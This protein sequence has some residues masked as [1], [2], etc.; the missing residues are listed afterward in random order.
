MAPLPLNTAATPLIIA[1]T[2]F[3]SMASSE[4]VFP[5][6]NKSINV[7]LLGSGSTFSSIRIESNLTAACSLRVYTFFTQQFSFRFT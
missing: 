6:F 3:P 5:F 1:I 4:E 2:T 7:S